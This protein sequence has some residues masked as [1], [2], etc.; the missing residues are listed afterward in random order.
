MNVACKICGNGEGNKIWL[1]KEMML[2]LRETFEYM[3]CSGCGCLQLV[4]V[5]PDPGKYYPRD[6]YSLTLS[7]EHH[8]RGWLKRT[9]KRYRDYAVITG[10]TTIGSLFQ[11]LLPNQSI[12]LG[13]FKY[14]GLKRSSRILD[15]GSGTGTIPYVF[16][17]AGFKHVLGIDPYLEKDLVYPN[18]LRIEKKSLF[19]VPEKE[20]WDVVMFN[21]SFE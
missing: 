1:A 11:M 8:F 9:I 20:A 17:N 6:Y 14:V 5:P 15:V 7:P 16:R 13:N 10:K 2:G 21:H 3:E 12:E 18:G 19:D 4:N